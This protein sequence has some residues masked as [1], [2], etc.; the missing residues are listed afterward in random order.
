M[1]KSGSTPSSGSASYPTGYT[2]E[3]ARTIQLS[4]YDFYAHIY[5]YHKTIYMS[6]MGLSENYE[7]VA[8]GDADVDH[9]CIS[10]TSSYSDNNSI[11]VI[12]ETY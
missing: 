1:T 6:F 9:I 8:I 5:T 4:M 12:T 10:T 2:K 3:Y 11:V 7:I